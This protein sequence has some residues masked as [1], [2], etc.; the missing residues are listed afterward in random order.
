MVAADGGNQEVHFLLHEINNKSFTCISHTLT[1]KV[2]AV[3]KQKF[4]LELLPL[5]GIVAVAVVVVVAAAVA[6]AAGC[7]GRRLK[8]PVWPAAAAAAVS[9]SLFSSAEVAA[10]AAPAAEVVLT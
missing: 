9:R 5:V 2:P 4:G 10:A 1:I 3:E 7:L 8:G 6:A